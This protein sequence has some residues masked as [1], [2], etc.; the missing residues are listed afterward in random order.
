MIVDSGACESFVNQD[1]ITQ[2]RIST[3][4]LEN[5]LKFS[6]ADGSCFGTKPIERFC[7]LTFQ[8]DE[9]V[10]S[11]RFYLAELGPKDKFLLGRPWLTSQNPAINWK[12]GAVTL[13]STADSRKKEKE[14]DS[15]RKKNGKA[16]LFLKEEKKVTQKR[17][18]SVS[19]TTPR[20][21]SSGTVP[22]ARTTRIAPV[23]EEPQDGNPVETSETV[24]QPTKTVTKK[25]SLPRIDLAARRYEQKRP[26]TDPETTQ[27]KTSRPAL[28][29]DHIYPEPPR[30][31]K[32]V[33]AV[34]PMKIE[35]DPVPA[36]YE[37][38]A[39]PAQVLGKGRAIMNEE[40]PVSKAPRLAPE[41]EKTQRFEFSGEPISVL[42]KGRAVRIEDPPTAK[43]L[44]FYESPESAMEEDP[45]PAYLTADEPPNSLNLSM[46]PA[47]NSE[48]AM[49][50]SSDTELPPVLQEAQDIFIE[51]IAS[52]HEAYRQ[53]EI[54]QE[55][56][57]AGPS[58][59]RFIDME[60]SEDDEDEDT[61]APSSHDL[62]MVDLEGNDFE[63]D[64][65]LPGL[66]F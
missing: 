9:R 33:P 17:K 11:E 50:L 12:T 62:R 6:N 37:F 34:Q 24:P 28:I 35:E 3:H 49:T 13:K 40:P 31:K 47:H 36:R 18:R 19:P 59:V 26:A 43:K 52:V 41:P 63:D 10:I 2:H 54:K 38:S 15:D 29:S 5:P 27:K 7:N 45:E 22:L 55:E 56:E 8:I 57:D 65:P 61:D 58:F 66:D 20:T 42:G 25:D 46:T 16:P 32:I 48:E 39:E 64:G 23:H 14:I 21:F 1:T 53:N 60:N 44:R 51:R 30:T 4:Q